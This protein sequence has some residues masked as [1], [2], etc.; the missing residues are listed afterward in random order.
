MEGKIRNWIDR[1]LQDKMRKEQI[2]DLDARTRPT[3]QVA[4]GVGDKCKGDKGKGKGRKEGGGKGNVNQD[5]VQ[6]LDEPCF[7]F[8]NR[9]CPH[10]NEPD[11]CRRKHLQWA[12]LTKAKQDEKKEWD[13]KNK[14][15]NGLQPTRAT[16]QRPTRATSQRPTRRTEDNE[17]DER[18][19]S[20]SAAGTESQFKPICAAYMLGKCDNT[21]CN[22]HHPR[23]LAA[24]LRKT[25]DE[26]IAQGCNLLKGALAAGDADNSMG[27]EQSANA[28]PKA[29][30]K[31]KA[32]PKPKR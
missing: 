25:V 3:K 14:E 2:A 23:A 26:S 24:K 10:Q 32:T 15:R 4:P 19:P 31:A 28:A 11:N 12:Q 7:H 22:K 18:K 20:P 1:Q 6:K 27:D 5:N 8:L 30:A 21:D 17:V 16:S 29:K 9:T 13:A